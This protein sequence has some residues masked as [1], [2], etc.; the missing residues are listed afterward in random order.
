M[1]MECDHPHGAD[2]PA[3]AGRVVSISFNYLFQAF[4]QMKSFDKSQLVYVELQVAQGQ[5]FDFTVDNL[6]FVP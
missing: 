1:G 6:A 3:S 5:P 2:L 4:G